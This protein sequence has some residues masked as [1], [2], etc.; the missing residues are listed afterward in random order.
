MKL[1]LLSP[2]IID[3]YTDSQTL[4]SIILKNRHIKDI[5]EFLNPSY[6]VFKLKLAS[7]VKAIKNAIT[8]GQNILIYGDYDVDGI[9]AAAILWQ[10]FHQLTPNVI[11][12]I[13]H[14]EIDGYGIKAG[15]FFRF[16][17]EKNLK[18]D[19]LITVDNGIV[20]Q[21]EFTKIK[22]RQDL[23]IIVVDHHLPDQNLTSVDFI[24]H[25]TDL[26]G[27]ALAWFLAKEFSQT[28]DLGLA[29]LGT[30]ADCLPL[31]GVNRSI[32]VHGLKEL[33][34]NPSIGIKKLI[35]VA[36]LK[37]DSLSAYDLGFGLGPRINAVGRLSDPT[38]AL[39]LL[40]SQNSLQASKYAQI[41]NSSN[42]NRQ[43][44]Q[45]ESQL[46]AEKNLNL[47]NK[48]IFVSGDYN[49]GLIGLI[50]GRLTEKYNLP[51]IIISESK[52]ISKGSCRSIDKLNIIETL[53]QF[54]NLFVDLG[55]HTGAAGFSIKTA[56]IPKFQKQIT[57]AINLKLKNIDLKPE[58][59]VDAEMKLSAV[60]LKNIKA[61]SGLTPFG[62]GNPVP[63]FL[64]K[65]LKIVSKRL[66]G[67]NGDHLKLSLIEPAR[68]N[69]EAVGVAFK[70]GEL[71]KTLNIGDSIDIVAS[72]DAN[73]WNGTTTPQL[74]VKEIIPY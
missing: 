13:P 17:K 69:C 50:A 11:P 45:K 9:T 31:I 24:V 62:I 66:L 49:P 51:S 59:P 16:Q 26:S 7:V 55:G 27:S 1:H 19:L 15:S 74:I 57:K 73:T 52:D 39:R 67:Q 54:S 28:A 40:C 22:A 71:D 25:S 56:N 2:D 18:F 14:R 34:L 12:F 10:I 29:A 48:V 68:P 60:T 38:D 32:I 35:T 41:L 6:P 70:K 5:P 65:N 47:K 64:F 30:V 63:L 23:T 61:I 72:L 42:Q 43:D 44:L 46:S 53:R 33:R 36:G 58:I 20:A 21:A 8:S 3:K 4:L 37:Q